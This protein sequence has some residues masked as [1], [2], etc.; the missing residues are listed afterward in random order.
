MPTRQAPTRRHVNLGSPALGVDP[1]AD[2]QRQL[3]PHAGEPNPLAPRLGAGGDVVVA[4]HLRTFHPRAV[5]GDRE[6]AARRVGCELDA[7]RPR[8][9]RVGNDLGE[10]R[11]LHGPDVGIA[12]VL[13]QVQQI[14]PGFTH[15]R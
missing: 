9:E 5:V 6:R 1:I 2:Q 3:D 14:D 7:L 8:V 12:E 15:G 13:E 11:L 4:P 10:D